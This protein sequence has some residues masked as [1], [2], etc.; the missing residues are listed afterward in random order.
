MWRFIFNKKIMKLAVFDFDNTLMN[1][2][3]IDFLAKEKRCLKEVSKIT[4]KA[5]SWEID[6]FESLQSRVRLLKGLE[7]SKVDEICSNLPLN[8]WAEIVLKEL[9]NKWYFIVCFS[10]G[11]RNATKIIREKWLIDAD[12][13]NI[14][15]ENNW[16]LTWKIG[17]DMMFSD[18][19]WDMLNRL[20]GLLSISV[21][22]TIVI[23]DWAN[24]VSMFKYANKKV[25]FC[26]NE[27]LKKEANIIIDTQD[28]SLILKYI[29]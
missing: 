23:W 13:A 3:T 25:A 28:L 7:Y 4:E 19:K 6:F 26:A 18:S 29:D 16:L 8:N 10:G 9:K 5:M 17:W 24:D 27:I 2:E 12:F 20:Q 21:N 1:W 14:L 22:D 11:F 15:H